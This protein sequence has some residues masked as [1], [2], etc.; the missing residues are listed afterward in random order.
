MNELI[1]VTYD[2]NRPTV[3]GRALHEALE[4][5]TEYKK[6]FGRMTEYGFAEG[7]DF[8]RVTQN[9]PTLG[10]VQ[11]MTDHQL[12]I[13]MAKELCMIQRTEKGREFRRYFIEVE[14]AWNNPE[15]V[16]ARALQLANDKIAKLEPAADYATKCLM[17]TNGILITSIAKEIGKSG[18][19]LNQ[20]LHGLGIQ[21]KCGKQ[22]VL[23]AK[24]ADKGY[25]VTRTTSIT[26]KDG[27]ADA[28]VETLWTQTGKQFIYQQLR[29]NGFLEM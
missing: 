15:A 4:V 12:T 10:G 13:D 22:W 6:W 17:A 26:R 20:I 19:W 23:Y 3:S 16:L 21:Y 8:V 18:Q 29:A 24:Y 5:K 27:K 9:C 11:A 28:R 14:K 2:N 25:T 1:K 7:Q